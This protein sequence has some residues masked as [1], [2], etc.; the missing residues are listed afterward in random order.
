[1]ANLAK[2]NNWRLELNMLFQRSP[3]GTP[4]MEFGPKKQP[5]TEGTLILGVGR[6][7]N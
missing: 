1:M 4:D 5:A 2:V 7:I 6:L 3:T